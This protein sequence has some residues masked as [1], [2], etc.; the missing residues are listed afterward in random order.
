MDKGSI[1]S[2]AEMFL[3]KATVDYNSAKALYK[4]FENNE[5]EIDIEKIYFDLQQC[6]EKLL[7]A[8]LSHHKITI[9]KTHDI[10]ALLTI[11]DKYDITI[12]N[13][14]E[15]LIDLTDYAVEG[16]YDIICD[17]ITDAQSYFDE[18]EIL[19]AVTKTNLL[20]TH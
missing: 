9:Q 14:S 3:Y 10:E 18:I 17:D 4:L 13:E 8:L 11:L 16:R 6:V 12:P 5:I 1:K 19:L 7:K 20:T 2:S 15:R